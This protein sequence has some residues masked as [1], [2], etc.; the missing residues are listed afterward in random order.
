MPDRYEDTD[1][2]RG[3][4]RHDLVQRLQLDLIALGFNGIDKA[5]GVFGRLTYWAVREFQAYAAMDHVAFVANSDSSV[6]ADQLGRVATGASRYQGAVSGV[7][8]QATRAALETWLASRWRCPVVVEAWAM[9]GNNRINL[10]AENI[11]RHD[12]LANSSPRMFVIDLSDHFGHPAGTSIGE[13]VALGDFQKYLQWSGPRSVP[14]TH[15]V[16]DGEILPDSLIG[17]PLNTLSPAE[18]STYKVV[19][20][21][22][23]V[24]CIGFYDSV[25]AY[26]NAFVS[27]GPC[28]WTLG[29]VSPGGNVSEGELCGFLAY[30]KHAHSSD[31]DRLLSRF[32]VEIDE[33]WMDATGNPTGKALFNPDSRKYV[34]W[35]ALVDEAGEARRLIEREEDGNFFKSWHWFYRFVAAGRHLAGYRSAMWT[36]ARVRLRDIAAAPIDSALTIGDVFTSERA[37]AILLRWHIRFP[38]H[39][40]SGGKAGFAVSQT[41]AAARLRLPMWPASP[42]EWDQEHENVLLDELRKGAKA[43]GG[44]LPQTIEQVDDWPIWA[45]GS[46]PRRYRLSTSIGGLATDRNSFLFERSGLP[47]P[48]Y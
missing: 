47:P 9:S 37:R 27:A 28:H 39:I 36:M 21:V 18:L 2:R 25:N 48:P 3:S 5:D 45:G 43:A 32:G 41:Y 1:L 12:H 10:V 14:P 7:V 35:V 31:Y 30:L 40:V 20:A 34:G 44:G 19:R 33:K 16:P 29:I 42:R 4:S 38:G 46:N 15:T 23:E 13:R 6:Y 17:K 8:D 11:W 24:E 26:D 22:S